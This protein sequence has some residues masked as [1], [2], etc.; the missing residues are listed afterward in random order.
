MQAKQAT[1]N[2]VFQRAAVLWW[3]CVHKKHYIYK[4]AEKTLQQHFEGNHLVHPS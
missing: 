1:F 2:E 3:L 4:I